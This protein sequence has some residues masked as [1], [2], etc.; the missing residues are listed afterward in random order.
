MEIQEI[1]PRLENKKR[2]GKGWSARCPAHDDQHNSLSVK[3]GQNGKVLL[4]CHAGCEY[5]DILESIGVALNNGQQSVNQSK[6]SYRRD[7]EA[8]AIYKYCDEK[9]ALLYEVL[10]FAN[11]KEFRPRVPDLMEG[12][13]RGLP[14]DVRRVLYRLP[15][16]IAA[17]PSTTVFIV[18]G[19]KDVETM[20]ERRLVSTCNV[21]G[22]GKWRD[23]Y[24]QYL[25]NRHV[26]ILP[27]HD[28]PGMEHARKVAQTLR[29]IAAS[30]RIVDLFDKK[31]KEEMK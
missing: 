19:E 18:E 27:D 14:T 16:L 25:R 15:E 31:N 21:G 10:R 12:H 26:C 17:D 6:S 20:R 3:E 8:T 30:V 9:G 29:G 5:K 4:F 7:E 13:R 2:S 1:L 22:A 24:N 23:E 28:K 11:P